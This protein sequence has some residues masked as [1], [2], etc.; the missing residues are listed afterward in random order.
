MAYTNEILSVKIRNIISVEN[1][2]I[3]IDL[4]YNLVYLHIHN[5]YIKY[6]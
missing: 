4:C 1:V 5:I 6:K 3:I 2:D